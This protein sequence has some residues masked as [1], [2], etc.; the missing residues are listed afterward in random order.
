[1]ELSDN[2]ETKFTSRE[3]KT[4]YVDVE[5]QYL[6]IVANENHNN[7]YNLFNQVAFM[8]IKCNGMPLSAGLP[9]LPS[10][11]QYESPSLNKAFDSAARAMHAMQ[12]G[13][14]HSAQR[15]PSAL[16]KTEESPEP[17]D[18]HAERIFED[19]LK[20]IRHARDEATRNNNAEEAQQLG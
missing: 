11:S 1:M 3:L 20:V 15:T 18:R 10:I 16:G 4:I 17:T 6:K 2:S 19:K 12:R 14:N 5:C 13:Q 9:Y 7:R 8:N